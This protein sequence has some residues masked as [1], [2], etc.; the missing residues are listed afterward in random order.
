[1]TKVNDPDWD[2]FVSEVNLD[3]IFLENWLKLKI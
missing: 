1:M 3:L 2:L